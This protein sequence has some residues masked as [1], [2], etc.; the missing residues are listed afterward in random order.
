MYADTKQMFVIWQ[1]GRGHKSI[2]RQTDRREAFEHYQRK[3][4]YGTFVTIKLQ[5]TAL[6][7]L[8]LVR[9]RT[10]NVQYVAWINSITCR[11]E[12]RKMTIKYRSKVRPMLIRQNYGNI[13]WMEVSLYA[14]SSVQLVYSF[15]STLPTPA[16]KQS[17]LPTGEG[18]AWL[19]IRSAIFEKKKNPFP[20]LGIETW[21]PGRPASKL[22]NFQCSEYRIKCTIQ[23]RETL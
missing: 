2:Y 15:I 1:W 13:R 20:S 19:Q 16:A 12:L 9:A 14:L 3:G 5:Q 8:L 6:V 21:F 11:K 23:W 10:A 4:I 22:V 7:F 17:V 18:A